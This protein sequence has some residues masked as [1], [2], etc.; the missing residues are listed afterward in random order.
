MDVIAAMRQK[1]GASEVI[2]KE[3]DQSL[4][5]SLTRL[6]L[7][8]RR[9]ALPARVIAGRIGAHLIEPF[10]NIIADHKNELT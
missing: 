8:I 6:H 9:I 7:P 1:F 5:S 4:H 10:C 3:K 2:G